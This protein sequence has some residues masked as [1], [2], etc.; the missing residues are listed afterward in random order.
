MTRRWHVSQQAH[1]F[2]SEAYIG[3]VTATQDEVTSAMAAAGLPILMMF[4]SG[5]GLPGIG[6]VVVGMPM[7]RKRP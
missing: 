6:R 4:Q 3:T 5:P 7:K 2:A 1:C